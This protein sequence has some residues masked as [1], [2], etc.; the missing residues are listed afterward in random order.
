MAT[1]K[2]FQLINNGTGIWFDTA[3]GE[4]VNI[5]PKNVSPRSV[6]NVEQLHKLETMTELIALR[7]MNDHIAKL[8]FD[9]DRGIEEEQLK[10]FHAMCI[11]VHD[12]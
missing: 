4:L 7:F 12:I 8:E 1:V 11:M 6:K 5:L 9:L 2:F 3:C 10:E